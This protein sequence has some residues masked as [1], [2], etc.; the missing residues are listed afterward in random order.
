M[1]AINHVATALILKRKFPSAP[2]FG[3]ALAT[4]A[5]EYLWVG[6]NIIGVEQTEIAEPMRSVADVHLA[7][8]PFSHSIVTSALFSVL[9]GLVVL[10]RGGKIFS[11]VALALSLAICSHIVLDLLVHAPDI[12]LAPFVNGE[13]YGT[14][15]YSNMPLS[16]LAIETFWGILCWHIYRGSWPLLAL[17]VTLGVLSVPI[18]SITINVGESALGGQPTI[19]ALVILAQMLATTGLVLLF[20]KEKTGS[21]RAETPISA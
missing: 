2:L 18:Y 19:F 1:Q 14:G 5:V 8:M 10:W 11:A 7:H 16:A 13:K 3:L 12:A 21:A 4:E 6:L 20:A 9:V 15:L 17:I